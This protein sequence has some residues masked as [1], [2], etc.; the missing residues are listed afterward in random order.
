MG[1]LPSPFRQENHFLVEL[2]RTRYL[3]VSR[4]ILVQILDIYRTLVYQ[5]RRMFLT[6]NESIVGS[7]E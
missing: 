1:P 2:F 7:P 4:A 6:N 3:A 5:E